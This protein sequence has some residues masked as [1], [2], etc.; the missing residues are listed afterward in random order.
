MYNDTLNYEEGVRRI[1]NALNTMRPIK[2]N[3]ERDVSIT[4]TFSD[5][6]EFM[7]AVGNTKKKYEGQFYKEIQFIG[8]KI[9]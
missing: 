4:K 7:E 6:Q 2:G 1:N 5:E 9:L 3:T 8:K